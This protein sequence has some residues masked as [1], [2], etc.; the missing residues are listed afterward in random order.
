MA[1]LVFVLFPLIATLCLARVLTD[2]ALILVEPAPN[3]LNLAPL[4]NPY[5]VPGTDI[6]LHF[7]PQ[8]THPRPPDA[9]IIRLFARARSVIEA[10][11]G[12]SPIP[13]HGYTLICGRAKMDLASNHLPM[14]PF[15]YS[16]ALSVLLGI[17]F[18]M[19]N[20]GARNILARVLRTGNPQII[21]FAAVYRPAI[22]RDNSA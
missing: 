6:T 2:T 18:K 4:P 15:M 14:N 7:L 8:P 22:A 5:P 12:N 9:D 16:D 13:G 3:N 21:G 10:Y 19:A 1:L 11:E 17:S 20:E